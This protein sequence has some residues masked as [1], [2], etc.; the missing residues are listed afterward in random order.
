MARVVLSR[1]AREDIE[2]IWLYI[3]ADDIDIADSILDRIDRRMR[4]LE[5]HPELAPLRPDIA[6]EIRALLVERWLV[7]YRCAGDEVQISRV[8]DGS[9]DFKRLAW[10][11]KP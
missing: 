5:R 3:A 10:P 6:A 11:E 4:M 2:A 9:R 7:L 8:V 1:L